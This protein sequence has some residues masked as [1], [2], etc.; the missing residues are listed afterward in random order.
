MSAGGVA[1]E[2]DGMPP[3]AIEVPIYVGDDDS[4]A[5]TLRVA[6][7]GP[8][9]LPA[10]P[11]A[12][13]GAA[14][15][16]DAQGPVVAG[17][18]HDFGRALVWRTAAAAPAVLH[19]TELDVVS[20]SGAAAECE[21]RLEFGAPLLP[22]VATGGVSDG[23]GPLL[24]ALTADG[25]LHVLRLADGA[26]AA[27]PGA[28]R[29]ALRARLAAPGAL[30]AAA[31]APAFERLG[32]PT[33]LLA[34]GGL[35]CVGTAS[36]VVLCLPAAAPDPAAA[37]ELRAGAEPGRGLAAALGGLLGRPAQPAV[38]ALAELRAMDR[39]LLAAF[40]ARGGLR[41]WDLGTRRLALAAELLPPGEGAA[42]RCALVR[43]AAEPLDAAAS[44]VLAYYEPLEGGA[45][46]G[47]EG[48]AGAPGRLHAF[49][50]FVEERG[51]AL[52]ATLEAGPRLAAAGVHRL[53]DAALAHVGARAVAAWLLYDDAG[54]WR[55]LA[56]I[57][58]AP[59]GEPGGAEAV[60]LEELLVAGCQPGCAPTPAQAEAARRLAAAAGPGAPAEAALDA[61]LAPG[62]LSRAALAA[63]LA[64]LGAPAGAGAEAAAAPL[65]S[66]RAELPRWLAPRVAERGE[67]AAWRDFSRAYAAAFHAAHRPLAVLQ[68]A[69]LRD[70]PALGLVR[71]GGLISAF[72]PAEPAELALAGRAPWAGAGAAGA[73]ACAAAAAAA[74]EAAGALAAAAGGAPTARLAWGAMRGGAEAAG[75]LAPA[76]VAAVVAG[77]P[78]GAAR[79]GAAAAEWRA[80]CRRL[81]LALG[82]LCAG[83]PGALAAALDA[84]LDALAERRAC[85]PAR[86]PLADG[87]ASRALAAAALAAAAQAAAA[88]VEVLLRLQLLVSYLR[89]SAAAGAWAL[90]AVDAAALAGRVEPRLAAL[91][92][93]AAVAAWAATEPLAAAAG[94]GGAPA[95]A[96]PGAGAPAKR[97]RLLPR[98]DAR[99]ADLLLAEWL[100]QAHAV[101]DALDLHAVAAH[102]ARWAMGVRCSAARPLGAPAAADEGGA[103]GAGSAGDAAG[104]ARALALAPAL[105]RGRHGAALSA[106]LR[107]ARP[108]G[109]DARLRFFAGCAAARALGAPG[110]PPAERAAAE[111]R[112]ASLFFTAAGAFAHAEFFAP[113]LAALGAAVAALDREATGAAGVPGDADGDAGELRFYEALSS[114]FA[115]L[116]APAAASRFALAGA[117][118]AAAAAARPGAGAAA[119]GA[120]EGRLWAAAFAACLEAGEWSCAYAA[121]LGGRAPA[122]RA[123]CAAALAGALAGA[124]RLGELAALPW[125]AAPG[126]EGAPAP[127]SLLAEA[128]G[129]LRRRA[130]AADLAAE[131]QPYDALAA[132]LT[133][134]GD[135][136]GAA[137]AR[138]A[139]ARRLAAE[140]PG[141]GGGAEA[142]RRALA[143]AAASLSLAPPAQRWLEEP[144]APSGAHAPG[145]TA[146]RPAA[147]ARLPRVLT[148][149]DLR[150]EYAAARA[151]ATVAGAMPGGAATSA[152]PGDA[153]EQLLALG[154][155]AEAAALA[156]AAFAG[157]AADRAA[158]KVAAAAGAAAAALQARAE[159]V[160][161]A[162]ADE[163]AERALAASPAGGAMVDGAVAG[164]ASAAA[165]WR[166]LRA[167]LERYEARGPGGPGRRPRAAALDAALAAAPGLCPP[168]WLVAPYTAGAAPL[169]D[170]VRVY[171]RRGRLEEAAEAAAARLAAAA[172]A[173]PA[174]PL[175]RA[176]GAC[177][178]HALLTE[179]AARL[180]AGG[181]AGAGAR[182]A[183]LLG[184]E[185]T[186]AA[187]R[188]EI[189][190]TGA[191][192]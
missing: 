65:A 111:A 70:A 16:P 37:F 83:P 106:L 191:G 130:D 175:P 187:R 42:L 134:R 95:P 183:E 132:F 58:V 63:A 160:G 131:P 142:A 51:G 123:D 76:I 153:F 110:V 170:L 10:A 80:A 115:R 147:D 171:M 77:P 152:A 49:E 44:T 85:G 182:L 127:A 47:A 2:L 107:L 20:G 1:D 129:A 177:L 179:L 186:A 92:A 3:V 135:H 90:D 30:R 79:R 39:P 74:L 102:F 93:A 190:A 144:G 162:A 165:A 41:L 54:G 61:A 133:A 24:A 146:P 180:Q 120:R 22:L 6:G 88:Q 143:A 7:G 19:L 34:L 12:A 8:V 149:A 174:A 124:G 21:A 122:L 11:R 119:A 117:Q 101:R 189:I 53:A 33:A 87:K 48:G 154:L 125:A 103:G 23:G 97:P 62:A 163:D 60:P 140:R 9:V 43:V 36:G 75:A 94:A 100:P 73:P 72:R 40:H 164:A 185:R 112:A 17:A 15:R 81:P 116:G 14:A 59:A 176:A 108:A 148:L 118:A 168:P 151:L 167:L 55:R 159:P 46:G 45:G 29:P 26:A 31:L 64:E 69:T 28:P 136:R 27:A 96:L 158:E 91:L 150:R 192:A 104:L 155:H 52:R 89:W 138:L 66:L 137:A 68:L 128:V 67:L 38:E 78:P 181:A 4:R 98:R 71:A 172:R 139:L 32:A 86:S 82:R 121:L 109:E 5:P 105:F 145:L 18:A 178:P 84:L 57:A 113:Q 13:A 56:R 184:A 25:V 156:D 126:S 173:A 169:A 161:A 188:S 141:D 50:V 114:L 166:R 99:A 157:A 35:L